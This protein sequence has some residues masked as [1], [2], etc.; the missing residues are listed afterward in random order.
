MKVKIEIDNVSDGFKILDFELSKEKYLEIT[1]RIDKLVQSSSRYYSYFVCHAYT[2]FIHSLNYVLYLDWNSPSEYI[3]NLFKGH[4]EILNHLLEVFKREWNF[5]SKDSCMISVYGN[6]EDKACETYIVP[7]QSII[8]E[9]TNSSSELYIIATDNTEQNIMELLLNAKNPNEIC[10]G[11]GGILKV[12]KI[13]CV[14][15]L[16]KWIYRGEYDEE[17]NPI[18]KSNVYK[19]FSQEELD[20]LDS[21]IKKHFNT[22]TDLYKIKVDDGFTSIHKFVKENLDPIYSDAC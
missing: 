18:Y 22:T 6:L 13:S 3:D 15:E 5:K 1:D 17:L 11:D 10:S 16:Y 12:K 8:Q 20:F 14:D 9:I 7:I 2:D 19:D 4:E 21:L